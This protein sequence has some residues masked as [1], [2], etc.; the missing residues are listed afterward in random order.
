MFGFQNIC[1][2]LR[3]LDKDHAETTLLQAALPFLVRHPHIINLP[4]VKN[5]MPVAR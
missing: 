3:P 4:I 1:N 2:T 5:C